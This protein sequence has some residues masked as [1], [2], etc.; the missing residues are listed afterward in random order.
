MIA[1]DGRVSHFAKAVPFIKG[2]CIKRGFNHNRIAFAAS[3]HSK[4]MLKNAP[5]NSAAC[6]PGIDVDCNH[7]PASG[8]TE[9]NNFVAELGDEDRAP[10]DGPKIAARRSVEQPT[11]ENFLRVVTRAKRPNG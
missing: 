7:H 1:R 2:A 6:G 10:A 3:R 4:C 11:L 9:A 5:P 8:L